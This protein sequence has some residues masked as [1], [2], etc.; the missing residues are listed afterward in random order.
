MKKHF[1]TF[2]SPGTIVAETT[3]KPI[4]SWDVD[5]AVEMS[6][7]VKERYGALPYAFRFSTRGRKDNELDSKIV[8]E[9]NTYYLG[10]TVKTLSELKEEG[11]PKNRTLISNMEINNWDKVIV[12]DNSWRWTQPLKNSDI[13]LVV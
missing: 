13:V 6:R 1:V 11:N 8:K 7:D 9:S 2:Y 4:D 12:N 3:R 5:K 10:G